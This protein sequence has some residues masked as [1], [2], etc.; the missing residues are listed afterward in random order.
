MPCGP[1]AASSTRVFRRPGRGQRRQRSHRRRRCLRP[2]RPGRSG[3]RR[4]AVHLGC[5]AR[6]GGARGTHHIVLPAAASASVGLA[7]ARSGLFRPSHYSGRP[8]PIGAMAH[9][10]DG[11]VPPPI[12]QVG[13][14]GGVDAV[15]PLRPTRDITP[16]ATSSGSRCR[17]PGPDNGK[18]ALGS[19]RTGCAA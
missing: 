5:G 15:S 7:R 2:L 14:H 6:V 10:L 11:F 16:G 8:A 19:E 17:G 12:Q 9:E 1:E 13:C 18:G 4:S 3:R